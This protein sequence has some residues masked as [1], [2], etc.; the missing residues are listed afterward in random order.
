MMCE[1]ELFGNR[2]PKSAVDTACSGFI[3]APE[4]IEDKWEF[5]R[6]DTFACIFDNDL[7]SAVSCFRFDRDFSTL[8]CVPQRVRNQIRQYLIQPVIV[9][10]EFFGWVVSVCLQGNAEGCGLGGKTRSEISQQV[11]K[12]EAGGVKRKLSCLRKG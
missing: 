4:S 10:A 1:H 3:A 12:Q 2:E 6:G 9:C 5:L 7:D 8:R 11:S